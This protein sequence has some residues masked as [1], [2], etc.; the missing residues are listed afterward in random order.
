MFLF[1]LYC[2]DYIGCDSDPCL[3]GATCAV[4][5]NTYTCA[6][7]AGYTGVMCETGG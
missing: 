3:N 7:P 4:F 5:N 2:I 6:C 1:T